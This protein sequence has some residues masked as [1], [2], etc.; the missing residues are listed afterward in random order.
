MFG[1][2]TL[3]NNSQVKENINMKIRKFLEVNSNKNAIHGSLQT[4]AK[5]AL[6]G[7]LIASKILI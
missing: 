1:R 3:L 5:T 4:V 7:K 2:Q 6:R